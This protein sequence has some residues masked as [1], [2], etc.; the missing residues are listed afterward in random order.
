MILSDLNFQYEN[1]LI[2]NQVISQYRVKVTWRKELSK[3]PIASLN[4]TSEARM[5]RH[6]F[7]LVRNSSYF[8]H[9]GKQLYGFATL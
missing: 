4:Y 8:I 9:S 5:F 7:L 3:C 1:T 6:H 2:S